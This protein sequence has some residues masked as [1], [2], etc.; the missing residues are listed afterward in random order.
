MSSRVQP[1]TQEISV[2]EAQ[3]GGAGSSKK[4]TPEQ[5]K[6]INRFIGV[7]AS[8]IS[9]PASSES[10][11]QGLNNIQVQSG[12]QVDAFEQA[13]AVS[14]R[15]RSEEVKAVA[16]R[17]SIRSTKLKAIYKILFTPDE[18]FLE[19]DMASLAHAL[20]SKSKCLADDAHGLTDIERKLRKYLLSKLIRTDDP[21]VQ[22]A[23][24]EFAARFEQEHASLL[25]ATQ[26]AYDA[27]KSQRLHGISLKEYIKAF[28]I[29][30]IQPTEPST[31]ILNLFRAVRKMVADNNLIAGLI[32]MK[33]DFVTVLNREKSQSP[34]R[35]TTPRQ[36]LLLSRIN[37]LNLLIKAC[38]LHA[39]FLTCCR[40]AKIENLPKMGELIES[41]LQAVSS[42]DLI[43][44]INGLVRLAQN[45]KSTNTPAK[46]IFITN[47]LRMVLQSIQLKALY[48][49]NFQKRQ[50][51]DGINKNMTVNGILAVGRPHEQ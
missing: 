24:F 20:R 28:Q 49:T 4:L 1:I 33:N 17:R 18:A 23:A 34:T 48:P 14:A 8:K 6:T 46:N 15:G 16:G 26:S 38:H 44:G 41:C 43:S 36:H 30:E 37:Q 40:K 51:L 27:G 45:V 31:H 19:K 3:Q 12:P 35:L 50:I 13:T 25:E 2:S 42:S 9:L 47:Y 32:R 29:A 21:D 7:H 11:A 10:Q 5:K 39:K 22:T